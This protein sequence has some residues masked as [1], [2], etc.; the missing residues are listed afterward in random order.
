MDQS[1]QWV[2]C[3]QASALIIY[4][5]PNY[6]LACSLVFFFAFFF[7]YIVFNITK[8]ESST[9]TTIS[10]ANVFFDFIVSLMEM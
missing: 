9:P 1:V 6:F 2:V 10:H 7:F 4:S 8:I 3:L 5:I